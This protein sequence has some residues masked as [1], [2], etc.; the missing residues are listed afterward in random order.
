MRTMPV[1]AIL[2]T[3]LSLCA[4]RAQA[5]P[6]CAQFNTGLNA[7]SFYSYQQ[8]MAALSGNGGVCS[9]NQFETPYLTGRVARRGYQ[10]AY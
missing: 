2:F 3:A 1:A 8:C 9:P 5:A 10:R 4:D 6:W 7:C